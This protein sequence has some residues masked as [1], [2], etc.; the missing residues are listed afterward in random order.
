MGILQKMR[1]GGAGA[2]Y[3]SY[4]FIYMIFLACWI[5]LLTTPADDIVRD[6]LDDVALV[7][8]SRTFITNSV[9][10]IMFMFPPFLIV[11]Y[12]W[13]VDKGFRNYHKLPM[14][15]SVLEQYYELEADGFSR[16]YP[17]LVADTEARVKEEIARENAM[18]NSTASN[19]D[20]TDI[21]YWFDL[22]QKGA[23]TQE[24]YEGKKVE[25]M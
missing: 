7:Y 11:L 20:K 15:E 2:R 18:M 23:I 5:F 6:I 9:A 12:G 22:L 17:E 19:I 4:F 10:S 24:E 1:L 21:G 3:T 16:A 14:N 25:L 8:G 13:F